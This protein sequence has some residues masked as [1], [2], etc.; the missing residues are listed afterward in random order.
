VKTQQKV[1]AEN[2][3]TDR[4]SDSEGENKEEAGSE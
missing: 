1:V 4:G 2:T 3:Y